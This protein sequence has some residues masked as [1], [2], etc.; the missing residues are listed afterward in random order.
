MRATLLIATLLAN[1]S[2]AQQVDLPEGCEAFGTVQTAAC[3]VWHYGRCEF[4][5]EGEQFSL[6]FGD[7][8]FMMWVKV[9]ADGQWRDTT[10]QGGFKD[11]LI[12]PAADRI[13]VPELLETDQ[14]SFDFQLADSDG[15]VLR[16][17]GFSRL[18]GGTLNIGGVEL[19]E[20]SG[21]YT[22]ID[23][24]GDAA[25]VVEGTSFVHPDWQIS[26]PGKITFTDS[27]GTIVIDERPI[28]LSNPRDTGFLSSR[29]EFGC[30][31]N[32]TSFSGVQE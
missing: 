3:T 31:V 29:P 23:E 7:A 24:F 13:S 26:L 6:Q 8:G 1:P 19:V 27:S 12:E 20:S 28:A 2:A 14:D 21:G 18:T 32:L 25:L 16:Y 4:D 22:A 9:D 10:W 15:V 30:E 17:Q 5:R 11:W